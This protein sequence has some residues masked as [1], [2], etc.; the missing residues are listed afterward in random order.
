MLPKGISE[1]RT[2]LLRVVEDAR[3]ELPEVFLLLLRRLDEHLVE[4]DQQVDELDA[5]IKQWHRNCELSQRLEKIPG[6]GPLT[7][8]ALVA[9]TARCA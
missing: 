5:Q 8:T 7:A 2:Q 3:D 9:S 4:L 1:L 6:V